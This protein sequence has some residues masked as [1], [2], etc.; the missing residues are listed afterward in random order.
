MRGRWS[1]S[2]WP[3]ASIVLLWGFF[4]LW[5]PPSH[6]IKHEEQPQ[7]CKRGQHSLLAHSEHH[8]LE[9]LWWDRLHI[10]HSMILWN[11]FLLIFSS[12]DKVKCTDGGGILST[13][14]HISKS[15]LQ[16]MEVKMLGIFLKMDPSSVWDKGMPCVQGDSL[17]QLEEENLLILSL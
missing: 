15:S 13:R 2:S 1:L 11:I 9:H 14:W 6:L 17:I 4:H 8:L 16:G 3:Q 7:V 12:R 5:L 10:S